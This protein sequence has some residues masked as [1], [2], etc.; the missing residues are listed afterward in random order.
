VKK[1]HQLSEYEKQCLEFI[2]YRPGNYPGQRELL[3]NLHLK[4]ALDK[5]TRLLLYQVELH[6]LRKQYYQKVEI[7]DKILHICGHDK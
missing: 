7:C 6:N 5:S 4:Y 1:Y 3:E 2:K